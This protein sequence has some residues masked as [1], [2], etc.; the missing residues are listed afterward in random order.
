M[1]LGSRFI[2]VCEAGTI[3][4]VSLAPS[5]PMAVGAVIE[6][7]MVVVTADR[8]GVSNS[9]VTV[10]VSGIRRG[11]HGVRFP[12]FTADEFTRNTAFWEGWNR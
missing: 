7:G 9:Y 4:V 11:R 1:V 2:S 10:K 6:D 5:I 12:Q 3:T 8:P